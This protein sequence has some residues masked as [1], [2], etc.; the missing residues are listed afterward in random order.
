MSSNTSSEGI[1]RKNIIEAE[2]VDCIVAMPGQ[3]FYST[4]IPVCLWFV[5]RNRKNGKFRNRT[6]EILFID[7]RKMGTLVDRVHRELDDKEIQKIADTYHS[8]RL[9]AL[10]AQSRLPKQ[11]VQSSH[12][13]EYEDIKGFCKSARLDELKEHEYILTPGRYVG[14]EDVPEDS[15]PFDEKMER[16]TGDLADMFAES[17]TLEKE[18][19]SN[20][21]MIGFNIKE[22]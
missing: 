8:W 14:I 16:I 3:L 2:L 18:I 12:L 20:L 13:K 1:I 6:G 10:R 21:G 19:R 5:S 17:H 22:L 15:E 11:S 4:G 7:A 9:P